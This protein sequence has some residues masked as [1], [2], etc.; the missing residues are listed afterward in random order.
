M[1]KTVRKQRYFEYSQEAVWEAITT[2]EA[3]SNW[4]MEADFKPEV[5]YQFT[6]KDTPQGGWDGILQGEV[7][8]VKAPQHLQYTWSGSQMTSITTVTWHLTAQEQGTLL[9]LEHSGF[10]GIRNMMIGFFHQFG[11]GKF[12]NS[13]AQHLDQQARQEYGSYGKA[14]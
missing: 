13:L 7:L 2:P 1:Q 9:S 12:L 3:L 8:L 4:F 6:F 14:S 5:G 11:W 10:D